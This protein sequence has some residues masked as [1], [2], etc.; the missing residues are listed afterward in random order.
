MFIQFSLPE[1]CL[2]EQVE[3]MR[4]G[5][6]VRLDE[7]VF[8]GVSNVYNLNSLAQT[9]RH[10]LPHIRIPDEVLRTFG[11]ARRIVTCHPDNKRSD[12]RISAKVI[13]LGT[14]KL[15]SLFR[16]GKFLHTLNICIVNT[17]PFL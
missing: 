6:Q 17:S 14:G 16:N 12:K 7:D 10:I 9:H 15:P 2:S 11:V 1:S 3:L 13:C 5:L 8:A 4:L